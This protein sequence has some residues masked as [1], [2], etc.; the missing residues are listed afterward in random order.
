MSSQVATLR[1]IL[2]QRFPGAVPVVDRTAPGV[3][4]GLAPLD[5]ILP[6][7]GLPRGRLSVWEPGIGAGAVLRAT[8][9]AALERGERAAWVDTRGT[10]SSEIAWS[11]IA[12][13]RPE[14]EHDALAC[15]E[16]LV[17]SGDLDEALIALLT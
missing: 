5:G 14:S 3:A 11:G 15:T 13:V 9:A 16:E 8:C 12:L 7:Q 10:A 6:G 17:R 4:T 1:G 2:E